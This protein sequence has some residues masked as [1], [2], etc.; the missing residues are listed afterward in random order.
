MRLQVLS[1]VKNI[2]K[3]IKDLA[4][5]IHDYLAY[6]DKFQCTLFI[7]ILLETFILHY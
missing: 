4:I 1:R 3:A 2:L 5:I 7:L 6:Q